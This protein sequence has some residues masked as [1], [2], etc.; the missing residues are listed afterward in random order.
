L[1]IY[2]R[3]KAKERRKE[4][5]ERLKRLIYIYKGAPREAL[6]KISSGRFKG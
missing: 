1:L 6:L 2:K 3:F 5:K 4:E